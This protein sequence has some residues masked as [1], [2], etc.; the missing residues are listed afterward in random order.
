M[1]SYESTAMIIGA[2]ALTYLLVWIF[3]RPLK[4]LLKIVANSAIGSLCLVLFNYI[5]TLFGISLGVNIY[6]SL[7]CGLFGIPGFL[8]LIAGKFFLT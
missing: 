4:F 8:M 6:S 2:F 7:I 5:G 1:V 3:M